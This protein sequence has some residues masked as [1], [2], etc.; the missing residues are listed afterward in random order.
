MEDGRKR[1]APVM[2]KQSGYVF[3]Q[4]IRRSFAAVSRAISKNSVPLGSENPPRFP[5]IEKRLAGKSSAQQVEVGHFIGVGFSDVLTEPLSFRIEQRPVALVGI[6]VD[7]T[8]AYADK[9]SGPAESL[10]EPADA[11]K[12]VNISLWLWA[13][14]SLSCMIL[15][16]NTQ[17]TDITPFPWCSVKYI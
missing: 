7:L 17:S 5:A 8:M 14:R 9:T 10:P 16:A 11:G 1:P 2:V 15:K 4:Q 6:F 3:K 12:Q 13:S